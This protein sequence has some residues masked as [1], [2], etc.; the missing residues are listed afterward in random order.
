MNVNEDIKKLEEL[1]S[2]I[3]SH[4]SDKN[5]MTFIE[6][7]PWSHEPLEN[8][9]GIYKGYKYLLRRNPIMGNWCGYIQIPFTYKDKL[10]NL[11]I[12]GGISWNSSYL[13]NSS[14]KKKGFIWIGFD[15]IHL[16]DLPPSTISSKFN[17]Y[18]TQKVG[19]PKHDLD[20]PIKTYKTVGF[21]IN[22]IYK[23]INQL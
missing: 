19:F 2:Q 21:C 17:E 23:F 4:S 18:L 11:Q 22:E 10:E 6:E 16:Q 1:F 14:N 8:I 5:L 13:P 7:G 20:I 15:T 9:E 12:H 3:S